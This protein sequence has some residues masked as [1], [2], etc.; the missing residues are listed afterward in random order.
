[1]QYALWQLHESA[2]ILVKHLANKAP[3]ALLALVVLI[4]TNCGKRGAPLP[5]KERVQQRA[6]ITAFQ[7]GN[8][9]IISW[10]MP[11]RNAAPGNVQ[12]I[13]S[14]DIFRLAEQLSSPLAMSEDEFASRS[15]LIASMPIT[16]ADFGLKTV[17]YRDSL[18]FA[19]QPV[20]LRYSVRY[21]N[22]AGQ[23]AAFSNFFLLEPAAQVAE[24]PTSLSTSVSQD[25][26]TLNWTA[27]VQN[28]D[29]STPPNILGYNIYRSPS[30]KEAGKLLNQ[31][32]VNATIFEDQTFEFTKEYFYF[33]RSVS[34]GTGGEPVESSESPIANVTPIDTF[35]PSAPT[36]ITIAATPTTIS[37]FFPPNPENDIAGYKIYRSLDPDKPLAEWE[38]MTK[39]LQTAT[40]FIDNRV[41]SGKTYFYYVT[42]TDKFGNVSSPSEVV[43]ETVP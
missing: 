39:E 29:G 41:E 21:V 40:T 15:T 11:A 20:R 1:M 38:L 13:A 28:I 32:P 22:A 17:S 36:S 5:P 31:T 8:Q 27:P 14:V 34:V 10:K 24:A 12:H 2:T 9:V 37:L 43:N 19:G 25:A 35:A 18:Q 6:E 4:G 33:V 23:R 42:A 16:D 26:V 7:R 30:A 3:L